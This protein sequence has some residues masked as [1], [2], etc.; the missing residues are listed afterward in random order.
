MALININLDGKRWALIVEEA[1]LLI[2]SFAPEWTDHNVHDPGITI[3]ELFSW[4]EEIQR[5]RLNRT[6]A[7]IRDRFFAMAGVLP[8]PAKPATALVEFKPDGITQPY[9]LIPAKTALSLTSHPDIPYRTVRDSYLLA[10]SIA[11]IANALARWVLP[12]PG[13][14]SNTTFVALCTKRRLANSRTKRSESVG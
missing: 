6:S 1:R 12:T 9:V 11:A 3:L 7:P 5:Y 8:A 13:G 10:A 4:L 2:P 14:P